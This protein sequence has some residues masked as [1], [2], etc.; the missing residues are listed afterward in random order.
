MKATPHDGY[1]QLSPMF[2]RS[3]NTFTL[4]RTNPAALGYLPVLLSWS[5]D[6]HSDGFLP[7]NVIT[8]LFAVPDD[9]LTALVSVGFLEQVQDGYRIGEGEEWKLHR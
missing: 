5:S 8:G 6:N 7:A 2:W 9:A 3:A 1:M 4:L